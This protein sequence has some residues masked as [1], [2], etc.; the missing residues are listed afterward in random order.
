MRSLVLVP[1]LLALAAGDPPALPRDELPSALVLEAPAFLHADQ[2]LPAI[3]ETAARLGRALFFDPL[4]SQD[5]SVACASCHQPAHGFASPDRLSAGVGGRVK[6][7]NAPSLAN[8]ALGQHFSWDGRAASLREQVLM[9]IEDHDEMSLPLGDALERIRGVPRLPALVRDAFP[10]RVGR[11]ELAEAL[12]GFVSTL[13]TTEG[14]IDRFR[15]G[16][17]GALEPEQ[18]A[19]LWLY[20]SKAGCWRCHTGANF[21][22]ESFHATGIGAREGV[23]EPGRFAIT[24]DPADVGRFKTPTLR[25]LAATAPYMHDGSLASITDVVAFYRK[26]GGEISERDPLLAPL[27]LSDA[28]AKSL[29]AFLE[30]LS[31]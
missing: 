23:A 8:R 11:D 10:E 1:L 29:I 17:F 25:G 28:E 4:L 14:P 30:A 27:E 5:K 19:G 15:A 20:E 18:R 16:A 26:G 13:W 24:K 7:R 3:R 31:R 2:D 9:P 21:T 22:D 12:A 6:G